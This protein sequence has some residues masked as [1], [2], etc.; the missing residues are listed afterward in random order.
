MAEWQQ[1]LLGIYDYE[2]ISEWGPPY[3]SK[4]V[5]YYDGSGYVSNPFY[6]VYVANGKWPFLARM[7]IDFF[8]ILD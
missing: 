1:L 7:T 8:D 5:S 6:F 4:I 3:F 2:G